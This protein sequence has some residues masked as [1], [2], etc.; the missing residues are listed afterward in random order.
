MESSEI[1]DCNV[2]FMSKQKYRH[3]FFFRIVVAYHH[4]AAETRWIILSAAII[5]TRNVTGGFSAVFFF[6]FC[7]FVTIRE[8]AIRPC[9]FLTRVVCLWSFFA[10]FV[11]FYKESAPLPMR[12]IFASSL[13]PA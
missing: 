5:G 12:A 8:F 4:K 10:L 2:F 7:L 1:K 3:L 9:R 6:H 13:F 11:C